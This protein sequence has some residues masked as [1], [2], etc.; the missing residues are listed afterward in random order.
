M[1]TGQLSTDPRSS[2][3]WVLWLQLLLAVALFSL[4]ARLLQIREGRHARGTRPWRCVGVGRACGRATREGDG[5]CACIL[6]LFTPHGPAR[7]SFAL[8]SVSQAFPADGG[9]AAAVVLRPF[10]VRV[11]R[12]AC[13]QAAGGSKSER[14]V[15]R[16][17][18]HRDCVPRKSAAQRRRGGAGDRRAPPA[19]PTRL[20]EPGCMG[21]SPT[22]DLQQG[23]DVAY[24]PAPR[25][26]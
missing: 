19:E 12:G 6:G 18:V 25:T 1:T 20:I 9:A 7:L 21:R 17:L 2:N 3:V 5:G 4:V 13:T 23:S 16:R 15:S 26:R 8:A 11:G 14:A 24:A 10:I 22:G